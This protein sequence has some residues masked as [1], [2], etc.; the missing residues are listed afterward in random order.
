MERIPTV[1]I[2]ILALLLAAGCSSKDDGPAP[3]P[4]PGPVEAGNARLTPAAGAAA[5]GGTLV[6]YLDVSSGDVPLGA[7][8]ANVLFDASAFEV[9]SVTGTDT[10]LGAPLHQSQPSAGTLYLAWLNSSPPN[11]SLIG[12]RRVAEITFRAIGAQGAAMNLGGRVTSMG[13]ADFLS[14]DVGAASFPRTMQVMEDVMVG[15]G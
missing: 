2:A 10:V 7:F 11:G 14:R 9:V 8:G 1:T 5:P 3:N 15:G 12:E 4:G 6:V 13:D